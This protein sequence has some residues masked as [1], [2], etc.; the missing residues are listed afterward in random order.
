MRLHVSYDEHVNCIF[1]VMEGTVDRKVLD[2]Y[3]AKVMEVAAQHPGCRRFLNDMRH[4]TVTFSIAEVYCLP[5]I[6]EAAGFDRSWKRALVAASQLDGYHFF[7]TVS[8][9]RGYRVRLFTDP[10]PA[11]AWLLQEGS[12]WDKPSE[13]RAAKA[14]H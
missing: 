13:A 10:E 2:E 7:E 12:V 3:T 1:G 4:A 5:G 6:I 14:S 9:N 11:L 8:V